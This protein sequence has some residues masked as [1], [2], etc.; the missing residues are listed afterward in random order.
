MSDED[1]IAAIALR[2][3][4][5][6]LSAVQGDAKAALDVIKA[7]RVKRRKARDERIKAK[8]RRPW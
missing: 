8:P 4:K 3:G 2:L 7:E 5:A 6:L 1:T